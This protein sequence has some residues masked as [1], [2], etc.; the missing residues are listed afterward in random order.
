[1]LMLRPATPDDLHDV[2]GRESDP[3]TS[4]WPGETGP[5]WHDRVLAAPDQ[6]HVV[7]TDSGAVV[8]FAVLA[9]L[10]GGE[11]VELRRMVVAPAHRGA[12]LGRALS[13]A[14]L[15]R[16]YARHGARTVWLDVKERNH[17]AR[18]L[19]GTSGFDTRERGGT[20]SSNP[21]AQP[22]TSSSWSTNRTDGLIAC[23]PTGVRHQL[24]PRAGRLPPGRPATVNRLR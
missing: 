17:R 24:A 4:A 19:Y 22:R 18:A 21:T 20:P 3:D 15:D 14:V 12:G 9:G 10:R 7:A 8:G 1:M 5:A 6:E 2:A 23:P 13:H 11:T 16:A